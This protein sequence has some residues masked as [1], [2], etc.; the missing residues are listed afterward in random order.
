MLTGGPPPEG[1]RAQRR[2]GTTMARYR[3]TLHK[4]FFDHDG[5]KPW[6]NV[7][8]LETSSVEVALDGAVAIAMIEKKVLKEYV[9]IFRVHAV[10]DAILHQPGGSREVDI[11]GEVT[12]DFNLMLPLFNTVRITFSDGVGRPSTRYFRCPL[13]EDEIEGGQLIGAFID[14][15]NVNYC[16]YIISLPGM[17]SNSGDEYTDAVTQPGVQMRQTDWHRRT[18]PGYKR[19]WVPV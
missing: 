9:K 18:R 6:S 8:Y 13:Q 17:V 5:F 3:V 19:G 10:Q 15:M 7:Y 1:M 12:G 2:K 16:A 11:Q 14:D 4:H